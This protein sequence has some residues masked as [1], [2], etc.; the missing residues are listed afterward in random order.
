MKPR[1]L[2][3]AIFLAA[4]ASGCEKTTEPIQYAGSH[5]ELNTLDD[6][7][8]SQLGDRIA[9]LTNTDATELSTYLT[10]IHGIVAEGQQ[11][12]N[13]EVHRQKDSFSA[14][15]VSLGDRIASLSVVDSVSLS[16]YL[17]SKHGIEADK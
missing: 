5:S 12:T 8:I 16:D 15:I 1:L 14:E 4:L 2:L 11:P 13:N 3:I 7:K 9:G 6:S 17:A 10:D